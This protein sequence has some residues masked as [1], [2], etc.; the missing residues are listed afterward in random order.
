MLRGRDA[1][2]GWWKHKGEVPRET[3]EDPRR[4]LTG[5]GAGMIDTGRPQGKRGGS[6]WANCR[7]KQPLWFGIQWSAVQQEMEPR[8]PAQRAPAKGCLRPCFF[9]CQ[10]AS[11]GF[12]DLDKQKGCAFQHLLDLSPLE[13]GRSGQ[14][15][16]VTIHS[17]EQAEQLDSI[18]S[19]FLC[20]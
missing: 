17:N 9:A 14:V 12:Q 18:S 10:H 16:L 2:R 15:I 4:M 6:S 13:A 8:A 19:H 20:S 1:P 3:Q 5:C 7:L 11:T